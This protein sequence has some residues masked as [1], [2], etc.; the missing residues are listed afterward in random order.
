MRVR[1]RA[2][3]RP[4][5][6]WA[7]AWVGGRRIHALANC[8]RRPTGPRP[9]AI[10]ASSSSVASGSELPRWMPVVS[11]VSGRLGRMLHWEAPEPRNATGRE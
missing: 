3:A 9:G 11:C 7:A 5:P 4:R 2:C 10:D 8:G 6:G 1:E